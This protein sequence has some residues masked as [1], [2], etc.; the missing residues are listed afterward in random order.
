MAF[1]CELGSKS[2]NGLRFELNQNINDRTKFSL[3]IGL[4]L[5]KEKEKKKN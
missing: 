1:C 5:E 2:I 3:R 4:L